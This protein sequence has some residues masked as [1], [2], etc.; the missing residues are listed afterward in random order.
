MKA[1][2]RSVLQLFLVIAFF[3]TC[4]R[5]DTSESGTGLKIYAGAAK[6]N[7]EL[8]KLKNPRG[9]LPNGASIS[10][11]N[12]IYRDPATS[13]EF[14][15]YDDNI[16]LLLLSNSPTYFIRMETKDFQYHLRNEYE[17]IKSGLTGVNKALVTTTYF[18]KLGDYQV[19]VYFA[20]KEINFTSQGSNKYRIGNA[21]NTT[22]TDLW[23]LYDAASNAVF[24]TPSFDEQKIADDF[25]AQTQTGK[26]RLILADSSSISSPQNYNLKSYGLNFSFMLGSNL[27]LTGNLLGCADLNNCS[28]K[29]FADPYWTTA[30]FAAFFSTPLGN[31]NSGTTNYLSI[32]DGIV[33]IVRGNIAQFKDF[34]TAQ[35]VNL[36]ETPNYSP[37]TPIIA[38]YTFGTASGTSCPGDY[39][40]T[41]TASSNVGILSVT[42]MTVTGATDAGCAATSSPASGGSFSTTG[43]DTSN[44]PTNRYYDF[45]FD[46]T[47]G[48]TV[49][50]KQLSASFRTTQTGP[51]YM[52]AYYSTA[53]AAG[54]YTQ[55][56]TSC[57]LKSSS[58]VNCVFDATSSGTLTGALTVHIRFASPDLYRCLAASGT[59]TPDG[60][61]TI[62]SGGGIRIDDV[63]L[64]GAVNGVASSDVTPPVAGGGGVVT[65]SVISSAQINLSWTAAT[66]NSTAQAAIV[67]EICQSTSSTGCNT[68]SATY[69][70]GA[71]VVTKSVTGLT[72]STTYYFVVR[73]KD[74]SGN[75]GLYTQ[76]SATTSAPVQPTLKNATPI[77]AN[78]VDLNFSAAMSAGTI[79]GLTGSFTFNNGLSSSAV[80]LQTISPNAN[81]RVRVSTTGQ[82]ASTSYLATVAGSVTD[83]IGVGMD[84]GNNTANFYGFSSTFGIMDITTASMDNLA[85]WTSP[86]PNGSAGTLTNSSTVFTEGTKSLTYSTGTLTTSC[87]AGRQAIANL[88]YPVT[89]GGSYKGTINLKYTTKVCTGNLNARQRIY[90]YKDSVGTASATAN[91]LDATTYTATTSW[92]AFTTASLAA[93]SDAYFARLSFHVCCSSGPGGAGTDLLYID[94]AYFGP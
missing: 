10:G 15:A 91:T 70:N 12:I 68:F 47:A 82:T 67:Y 92:A 86:G 77:D 83:S 36:N 35:G 2:K 79:D 87:T 55:L 37:P 56:G 74:A 21:N 11:P 52:A 33:V 75:T 17:Q 16:C 69:T 31:S 41:N 90:W 20:P 76:T 62:A 80:T 66:D 60:S 6:W 13:Y 5:P 65:P 59:C 26:N 84:T 43:W 53:G 19:E 72:G 40:M 63:I 88:Y 25:Y 94:Q 39:G 38:T 51:S 48:T 9:V 78:T 30:D 24:Y 57:L 45:A 22:Y 1:L 29:Y 23:R 3:T 4:S 44:G 58:F 32:N 85:S 64:K 89:P 81:Q 71:G 61:T 54:P 14:F 27:T 73:A 49:N 8:G 34:V 46:L 28:D 93:P 42:N 50:M 7:E 18:K